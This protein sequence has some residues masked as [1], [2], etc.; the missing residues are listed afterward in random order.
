MTTTFNPVQLNQA[1]DTALTTLP[2]P[3]IW[4]GPRPSQPVPT[5]S[6]NDLVTK[7]LITPEEQRAL[8]VL[9]TKAH[10]E[11]RPSPKAIVKEI[12][13]LLGDVSGPVFLTILKVI[14]HAANREASASEAPPDAQFFVSIPDVDWGS[15][16]DGAV[17]GAGYGAGV[18]AGLGGALGGALAGPPG[19][20]IG[21]MY[22]AFHMGVWGGVVGGAV[23]G[24][25]H[26]A[27]K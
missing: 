21:A 9:L 24:L 12:D 1:L 8:R 23:K 19:A 14:R 17:D 25:G 5:G 6:L 3:P 2:T 11:P 26:G 20:A 15:A 4:P 18:G 16:A 22:G 7:G 13:R 10:A 27:S